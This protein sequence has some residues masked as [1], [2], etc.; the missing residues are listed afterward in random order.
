MIFSKRLSL[1]VL[2]V[3]PALIGCAVS[4]PIGL[5]VQP[6]PPAIQS[7]VDEARKSARLPGIA[8]IVVAKDRTY[9]AVSGVRS[10]RS[11]EPVSLSD[12]WHIGSVTKMMTASMVARL[13][14]QGVLD[15]DSPM[16][17]LFDAVEPDM[18][19]Q[20]RRAN[21]VHFLSHRSGMRL[22][23]EAFSNRMSKY[24]ADYLKQNGPAGPVPTGFEEG[25]FTGDARTD[26]LFWTRAALQEKPAAALGDKK[27][28]YE[29]G[30]YV[31]AA[32]IMEHLTGKSYETLMRENLFQPLEMVDAGFGPPGAGG[33]GVQP[34]GHSRK[35]GVTT[36][37]PPDGPV[38]PDNPPVLSPSGRVHLTLADME[39]FMRD[40]ISG[41]RGEGGSLQQKTYER[42]HQPPFGDDYALGW[43]KRKSGGLGHG[44]TNGKWLAVVEIRPADQAGVFAV[45]N[46][47]PPSESADAINK[48]ISNLF[49][50][51]NSQSAQ[52]K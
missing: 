17:E 5:P 51:A 48:L 30:N 3:W 45:T 42:L 19:A 18:Q 7:L 14:E 36:I 41:R 46:L 20:Y 38:R 31:V 11:K 9:A 10:A 6:K 15:W 33:D 49:L 13:V 22:S 4:E 29:N 47:G 2:F 1:T 12:K 39:K 26:R 16:E 25:D 24:T 8:A 43:I 50:F 35:D 21:I 32:A 27:R 28:I 37:F 34:L 52:E 44:G 40:H 23:S